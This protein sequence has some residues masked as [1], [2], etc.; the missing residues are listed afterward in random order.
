MKKITDKNILPEMLKDMKDLH[1]TNGKLLDLVKEQEE[2]IHE[3]YN[4]NKELLE[5]VRE[6]E[7]QVTLSRITN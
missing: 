4:T 5:R 7:F 2:S 3:Q 1:K 6:L